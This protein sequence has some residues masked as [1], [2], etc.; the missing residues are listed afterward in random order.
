[1]FRYD[2]H[3]TACLCDQ[4]GLPL[5]VPSVS[6]DANHPDITV[7]P[8]PFSDELFLT[9]SGSASITDIRLYTTTGQCIIMK[10]PKHSMSQT[11]DLRDL[12]SGMYMLQVMDSDSRI[13][14][15]SV[16]KIN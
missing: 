4:Q 5:A 10:D 11:L 6:L 15:K 12:P 7:Y 3:R 8:N 1:M 13:Y 14:H 9:C 16:V 2:D